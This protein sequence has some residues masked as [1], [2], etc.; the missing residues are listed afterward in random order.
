MH[1]YGVVAPFG[2]G[3][4]RQRGHFIVDVTAVHMREL[5]LYLEALHVEQV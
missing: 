3:Y 5:S 2:R 4:R 1:Y